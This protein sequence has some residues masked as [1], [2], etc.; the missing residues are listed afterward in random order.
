MFTGIYFYMGLVHMPSLG[1][2]WQS[3]RRL[4]CMWQTEDVALKAMD[5]WPD[6][7]FSVSHEEKLSTVFVGLPHATNKERIFWESS[8]FKKS[9]NDLH[10]LLLTFHED[11]GNISYYSARGK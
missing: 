7:N 6:W 3:D 4:I 9:Q 1:C 8:T 10:Q 2:N 5:R 11:V